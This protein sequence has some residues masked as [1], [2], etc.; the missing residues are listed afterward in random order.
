MIIGT[1]TWSQTPVEVLYEIGAVIAFVV[2]TGFIS[3]GFWLI[4]ALHPH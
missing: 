1:K 3:L 2:M 4:R